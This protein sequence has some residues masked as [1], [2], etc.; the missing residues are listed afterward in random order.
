MIIDSEI[1]KYEL[2]KETESIK[3]FFKSVDF[4]SGEI[5]EEIDENLPEEY[6]QLGMYAYI[7]LQKFSFYSCVI[8]RKLM[9][10]DKLSQDLESES[11]KIET[12]PKF[13]EAHIFWLNSFEIG[14]LYDMNSP[15]IKQINIKT[16]IDKIIHS[17]HFIL[18]YKWE[19][20]DEYLPDEE[21]ENWKNNGLEGFYFS[22]DHS[23]DIELF[24]ITF[25]TF[26]KII[27]NVIKD[28][29]VKK[30]YHGDKLVLKSRKS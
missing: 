15:K 4:E 7:K 13:P 22:S 26:I 14:K 20:I 12:Y 29:I 3:L 27:E 5:L 11:Y 16:L 28:N 1:W 2:K 17:F 21:A 23:K 8:I 19:K 18:S 24:Y 25:D 30:E 10:A 9:E 6:K